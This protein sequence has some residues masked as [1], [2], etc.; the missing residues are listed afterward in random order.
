MRDA[1]RKRVELVA[2]APVN[3]LTRIAL[4][5]IAAKETERVP[6]MKL[7][8][9]AKSRRKASRAVESKGVRSSRQ[10]TESRSWERRV[11]EPA[12]AIRIRS[13][14]LQYGSLAQAMP[15]SVQ[16]YSLRHSLD[17]TTHNRLNKLT[18][19]ERSS[20][21]WA[22]PATFVDHIVS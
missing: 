15:K 8:F 19:W 12:P 22:N 7:S 4:P 20:D 14:H 10:D 16:S 13:P 11:L 17:R 2:T 5:L 9:D 6:A 18:L 21:V 3:R 1:A